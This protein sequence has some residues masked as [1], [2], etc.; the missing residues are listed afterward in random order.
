MVGTGW[1]LSGIYR[2]NTGAYLTAVAG[3]DRALTGDVGPQR[4]N[5]ILQNPYGTGFNWINPAAFAQAPTGTFG[6][7]G[8]FNLLGPSYWQFDMA[9]SRIFRVRE[10]Q[11]LELRAEAFNVTNGLRKGNPGAA[12]TAPFI[13]SLPSL[14]TNI[15]GLINTAGDP[16]IMQFALKYVF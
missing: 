16:R 1:R 11:N 4:P 3:V 15:F 12:A 5:Q 8:T 13:S 7:I 6:N 14:N 10:N 9:L 2:W